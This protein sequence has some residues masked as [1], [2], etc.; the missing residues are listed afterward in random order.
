[1]AVSRLLMVAAETAGAAMLSMGVKQTAAKAKA[2]ITVAA[3]T[4]FISH[5]QFN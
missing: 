5:L 2:A 1:M 4:V 3:F